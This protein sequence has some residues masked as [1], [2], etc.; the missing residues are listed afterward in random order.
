MTGC[1]RRLPPTATWGE[2][3]RWD[4]QWLEAALAGRDGYVAALDDLLRSMP[5]VHQPPEK[6]VQFTQPKITAA[7]PRVPASTR[8]GTVRAP[9]P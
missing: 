2:V 4:A 6:S 3:L 7:V 1:T 8:A 9:R 5:A